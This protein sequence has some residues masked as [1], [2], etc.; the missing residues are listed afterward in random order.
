[1]KKLLNTTLVLICVVMMVLSLTACAIDEVINITLPT[2]TIGY[3]ISGNATVAKGGSYSFTVEIDSAYEKSADF[4]VKVNGTVVTSV[5]GAYTIENVTEGITIEVVGVVKKAEYVN[6]TLPTNV[7]GYTVTGEATAV[8]GSSYSFT[9]A[10]DSDYEKADDFAV[11]AN[12]NDVAEADGKY[13]VANVA[14][15][16][17]ITV[18]G[19]SKKPVYNV[20]LPTVEGCT[21][22]GETTVMKGE[23]YSFTVAIDSDSYQKG[24]E[25]AVKVNG[26]PVDEVNGKYT[27]ENVMDNLAITVE[28]V[29]KITIGITLPVDEANTYTVTGAKRVEKGED[30]TFTVTLA[31]GY[32]RS[33]DFA[34]TANGKPVTEVDGSEGT[35]VIENVTSAQ[36]IEVAGVVEQTLSATFTA[37][38]FDDA[39]ENTVETFTY[40]ADNFTFKITLTDHYKQGKDDISVF[41]KTADTDEAE[42]TANDEGIYSIENPHKDI[43]IIVKNVTLNTYKVMFYRNAVVKQTIDVQAKS[44]LTNDQ[45]EAAQAAVVGEGETFVAWVQDV[46]AQIV[47]DTAIYAYTT[48]AFGTEIESAPLVESTEVALAE[49]EYSAAGFSKVYAKSGAYTNIFADIDLQT[50]AEVRFAFKLDDDTH[51]LLNG[52]WAYVDAHN[53]WYDVVM[54]HDGWGNWN[55]TVTGAVHYTAGEGVPQETISSFSAEYK[56]IKLSDIL[57]WWSDDDIGATI[58]ITELR[59]TD[60]D[61]VVELISEVPADGFEAST[62][63]TAP[64]GFESVYSIADAQGKTFANVSISRYS[65]VRFYFALPNG[66]FAVNGWGAYAEASGVGAETW[67]PVTLVNNGEGNWTITVAAKLTGGNV[68]DTSK[69]VYT[70]TGS[71]LCDVL[72]SWFSFADTTC[73]YLTEIRGVKM[74][75]ELFGNQIEGGV[76]KNGITEDASE[77]IPV[78]FEKVYKVDGTFSQDKK[79]DADLSGYSKVKFAI[80]SDASKYFLFDNSWTLFIKE[81]Y[82]DWA[83]VTMDNNGDGTWNV[84]VAG[85]VWVGSENAINNPWTH[86]YTGDSIA[87][88]LAAWNNG[89]NIYVTELR[90]VTAE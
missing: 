84:T 89:G 40:F 58:H 5:D 14:G 67:V 61:T 90:G 4:A 45:L 22:T 78:G 43:T 7:E 10:I 37:E 55:V 24:E 64:I 41:W 48:P 33:D 87:T 16:L 46:T 23:S 26:E 54:I 27:V 49:G 74:Q 3:T 18:V 20:T 6:V 85:D 21:V 86:I 65:E 31:E 11:K 9:V 2:D 30:Y 53:V 51:L 57:T 77:Q 75:V 69:Y 28:G 13:T 88:I 32:K 56:G 68:N 17:T 50:A 35:F 52:Y 44:V 80:K 81:Q 59:K 8:K 62:D 63:K 38:N 82:M 15:D 12:G 36:I 47:G 1:M 70:G 39:L 29:E 72:N 25:F 34:V 19:V 71:K 60:L 66:Y 83:F 42:L 79:N 73:V 76:L